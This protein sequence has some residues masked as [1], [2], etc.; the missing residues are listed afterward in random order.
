MCRIYG[1]SSTVANWTRSFC[2]LYGAFRN[3]QYEFR[4]RSC[5]T[6]DI[7]LGRIL[8]KTIMS[9]FLQ[10]FRKGLRQFKLCQSKIGLNFIQYDFILCLFSQLRT[11]IIIFSLIQPRLLLKCS[12]GSGTPCTLRSHWIYSIYTHVSCSAKFARCCA[13]RHVIFFF[14]LINCI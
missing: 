12:G 3:N 9:Q 4:W 14:F 7:S 8:R 13:L 1:L 11:L 10:S 2:L 5:Y 6:L